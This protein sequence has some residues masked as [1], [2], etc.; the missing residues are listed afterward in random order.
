MA[1]EGTRGLDEAKV[2]EK[3]LEAMKR[4]ERNDKRRET[5]KEKAWTIT[6]T[7]KKNPTKAMKWK[8]RTG[9]M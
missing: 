4:G 3:D 8:R 2:E 6:A 9:E 1:R 5:R 7:V